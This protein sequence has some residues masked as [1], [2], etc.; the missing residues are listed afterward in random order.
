MTCGLLESN[1]LLVW[2]SLCV[3]RLLKYLKF[4]K[5]ISHWKTCPFL[6]MESLL[7]S[8]ELSTIF[9]CTI[10]MWDFKLLK[11]LNCLLQKLHLYGLSAWGESMKPAAVLLD[12]LSSFKFSSRGTI[13]FFLSLHLLWLLV[14]HC[15]GFST[16]TVDWKERNTLSLASVSSLCFSLS[17]IETLQQYFL[18]LGLG[19][20]IN[21]N[22][23]H[24]SKWFRYCAYN[25]FS[26]VQGT[27]TFQLPVIIR[28]CFATV[29]FRYWSILITKSNKF[30]LNFYSKDYQNWPLVLQIQPSKMFFG[31]VLSIYLTWVQRWNGLNFEIIGILTNWGFFKC[32]FTFVTFCTGEL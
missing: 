3:L 15:D 22:K 12:S 16:L 17:T 32:K 14:V 2:T 20:V 27:K 28:R 18:N 19:L 4:L 24:S 13:G 31:S 23:N 1:S 6:T 30:M 7:S 9:L 26:D 25:I 21:K 29:S 5:Q 10:F 8:G 11:Y